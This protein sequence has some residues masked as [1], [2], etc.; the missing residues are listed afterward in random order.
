MLK[1]TISFIDFNKNPRQSIEYFNLTEEEIFDLQAHSER[2]LDKEMEDAILSGSVAEVYDFIKKLVHASYGRK[3][4]D[5]LHFRKSPEILQEFISS[6]FYSDFLL[7]M[8][9]NNG[10]KGVEF[11][12][13]ILPKELIDRAAAQAQGEFVPGEAD[14]SSGYAPDAR[15]QFEKRKEQLAQAAANAFGQPLEMSMNLAE[16]ESA[17]TPST[18]REYQ[19]NAPAASAPETPSQLSDAERAQFEQWRAQQNAQQTSD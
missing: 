15:E 9:K 16:Q 5:G 2:G 14:I 18:R 19:E 6:A 17:P 11:V 10:A 3:S 8:V 4:D 13:G 12:N 7:G 1:Q